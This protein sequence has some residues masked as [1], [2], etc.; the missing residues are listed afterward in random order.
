HC[1]GFL[2]ALN[3]AAWLFDARMDLFVTYNNLTRSLRGAVLTLNFKCC[4]IIRY[5]FGII[6]TIK[7]LLA[8][9]NCVSYRHL[10]R[11]F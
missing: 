4:I 3:M 10:F 11:K 6:K 1:I 9:C 7:I 2:K 8:G 5:R